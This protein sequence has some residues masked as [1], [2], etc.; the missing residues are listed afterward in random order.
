[1]VENDSQDS[2]RGNHANHGQNHVESSQKARRGNEAAECKYRQGQRK[3]CK[4]DSRDRDATGR[5]ERYATAAAV[6]TGSDKYLI[7]INVKITVAMMRGARRRTP[8]KREN[9]VTFPAV[10]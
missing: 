10:A 1:M 9:P 2:H 5:G 4:T 8:A 7:L 6:R 3:P